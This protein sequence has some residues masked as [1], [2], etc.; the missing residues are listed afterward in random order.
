MNN[1]K[2]ILRGLCRNELDRVKVVSYLQK[3]KVDHEGDEFFSV[4]KVK[5]KMKVLKTIIACN[6]EENEE[7][8]R[9]ME[10][11]TRFLDH[12]SL[13]TQKSTIT[14]CLPGCMYEG[15][16]HRDYLRHLK[17]IHSGASPLKCQF[18]LSC[19]KM[20]TNLNLL[21]VHVSES[22]K[23]I[24]MDDD[25]LLCSVPKQATVS[26]VPSPCKCSFLKCGGM[27]FENTRL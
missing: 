16:K 22:H 18:G 5:L 10:E 24:V 19:H 2:L 26:T 23:K 3:F 13:K 12:H 6:P 7:L 20:F 1:L 25:N 21:L 4:L 14:C 9:M 27:Q 17:R 11:A 8:T 15:R